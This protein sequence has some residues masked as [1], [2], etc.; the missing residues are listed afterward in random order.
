MR[1]KVLVTGA[2]GQLGLSIQRCNNGRFDL[3]CTDIDTLSI[4]DKNAV[5]ECIQANGIGTIVNC[6]AYTAVDKAETDKDVAF[7]IN[8]RGVANL[9]E[10]SVAHGCRLIHVS[11][12]FVFDG[13]SSTP[14]K[15]TDAT[16]PLN[17]YGASKLAGEN[18]LERICEN[19]VTLRTSWLYS[20]YGNNFVK[21]MIRLT[22]ERD[23]I[24]I[25]FDQV[26]TPTYAGDLASQI[27]LL[28]ASDVTGLYHYS[29]EG[30]ASWYDF[31]RQINLLAGNGC[32]VLPLETYE[33][34]TP[35]VRPSYS[36]MNK[37]KF[38]NT[39]GISIPHWIDSLELCMRNLSSR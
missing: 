7:Q 2:N 39:M 36:V 35:A 22:S 23:R 3:V 16:N 11:T 24:G 37:K 1:N 34:P 30:V 12:D 20:E 5:E 38:K 10:L 14:Y 32:T 6:S 17:V 21:T 18:A 4:L 29:N 13:C 9:A 26:G 28:I 27:S 19:Y 33:Y 8:E 15:E 31:A 25:I